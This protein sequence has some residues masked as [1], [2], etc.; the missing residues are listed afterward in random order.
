MAD[1]IDLTAL[2]LSSELATD[3]PRYKS[4]LKAS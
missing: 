1:R 3:V 4:K 2:N